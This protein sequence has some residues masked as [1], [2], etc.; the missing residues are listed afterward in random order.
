ML[1]AVICFLIAIVGWFALVYSWANKRVATLTME[2]AR[3]RNESASARARAVT[4]ESLRDHWKDSSS[5]WR[6]EAIRAREENRELLDRITQMV[7]RP[8]DA[9]LADDLN[10]P[11]TVGQADRDAVAA[12]TPVLVSDAASRP[13][14]R[15]AYPDA[16]EDD[17]GEDGG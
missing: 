5:V 15:P 6:K 3:E 1:I 17:D 10:D 16:H 14:P 13:L 11:P 12:R 4:A 2:L 8:L 7:T 9:L